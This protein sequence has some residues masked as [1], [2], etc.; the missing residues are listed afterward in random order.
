MSEEIVELF[1]KHVKVQRGST[2]T[3]DVLLKGLP[4]ADAKVVIGYL[5]RTKDEFGHAAAARALTELAQGLPASYLGP[6]RV[7]GGTIAH[8]RNRN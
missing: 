5:K 2:S 7:N 6:R 3:V 8:W 4:D 1:D